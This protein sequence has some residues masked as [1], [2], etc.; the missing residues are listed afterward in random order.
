MIIRV[1]KLFLFDSPHCAWDLQIR[2]SSACVTSILRTSYAWQITQSRDS[3]YNVARMSLW[4]HAEIAIG[5]IVNCVPVL[6]RFFHHFSPKVRA[7]FA[8][9][10]KPGCSSSSNLRQARSLPPPPPPFG[11][12]K[13]QDSTKSSSSSSER[14]FQRGGEGGETCV[15]ETWSEA[16]HPST[17]SVKSEHVTLEDITLC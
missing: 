1:E 13:P 11:I 7:T 6:P 14:L 17:V 5:I 16:F 12:E 3:S 9:K 8:S 4:T 10:S 15:S 2:T